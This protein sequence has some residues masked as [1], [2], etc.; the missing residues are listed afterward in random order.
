MAIFDGKF[1]IRREAIIVTLNSIVYNEYIRMIFNHRMIIHFSYIEKEIR[2]EGVGLK[3]RLKLSL[4]SAI[5]SINI[6][7]IFTKSS[8]PFHGPITH[9]R[10]EINQ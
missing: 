7:Y 9:P 10:A 3:I 8:Y 6:G 5:L 1:F 4:F 2:R